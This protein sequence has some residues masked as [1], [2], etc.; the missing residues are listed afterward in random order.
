MYRLRE[1]RADERGQVGIGT[2][3]VFI[4]MVLVAAIAAGVLINTAGFLQSSAEATGQE[5]SDSTT[6][7]VQ[8][9]SATASHFQ[10][11]EVGVVSLTV[12]KAPGSGNV[13]LGQATVQWV[14]PSGSY[15]Q[16]AESGASGSP[17]GRFGV[18]T[19]QDDDG[20][21]PVLDSTED[22]FTIALDIGSRD[23]VED[24]NQFGEEL[25]EGETATV[26][27]TTTS[28]ATTTE[29]IVVPKTLSGGSAVTV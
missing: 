5:S 25:A 29:R 9:V 22:R 14:G 8:V 21:L 11:D 16:L 19:V 6:N 15:Y 27:I 1:G 12:K 7:R 26:R 17:D 3:I 23:V 18:S 24:G 13:D 10:D 20:S 4:A 28:G 2:L